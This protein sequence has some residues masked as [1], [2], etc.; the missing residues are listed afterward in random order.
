MRPDWRLY[1]ARSRVSVGRICAWH[2][3]QQARLR[4]NR[5]ALLLIVTVFGALAG[6]ACFIAP[7]FAGGHTH[8]H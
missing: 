8:L 4:R 6:L 2:A 5:R 1:G 7:F 3:K